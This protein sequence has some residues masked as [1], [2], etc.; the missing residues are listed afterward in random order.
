MRTRSTPSQTLYEGGEIYRSRARLKTVP[1][2]SPRSSSDTR[3]S[4]DSES[5]LDDTIR[6]L[7]K[8]TV[9]RFLREHHFSG[10]DHCRR[11]SRLPLSRR[12]CPLSLAA[13]R[14]DVQ[15][16]VMLLKHGADPLLPKAPPCQRQKG[17]RGQQEACQLIRWAAAA[18][19]GGEADRALAPQA[20]LEAWA[21]HG[22][23][24]LADAIGREREGPLLRELRDG[25]PLL[26]QEAGVP[27]PAAAGAH[28][29]AGKPTQY[30]RAH[31]HVAS[32]VS[33][34]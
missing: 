19:A 25:D 5:L 28:S 24:H 31:A 15:M 17:A 11:V 3:S 34:R 6:R 12:C 18:A 10:I 21:F 2:M 22:V 26:R 16:V 30:S 14:G 29:S 7:E 33:T 27:R 23:Y 4:S 8:R 13:D 20:S 32:R 1:S 9:D